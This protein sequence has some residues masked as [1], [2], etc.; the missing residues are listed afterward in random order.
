MRGPASAIKLLQRL[1]ILPIAFAAGAV[2]TG[3]PDAEP[4]FSSI[5]GDKTWDSL[6]QDERDQLACEDAP[7]YTESLVTEDEVQRAVC[8][9][10]GYGA[11][12]AAYLMGDG[13]EAAAVEACQAAYDT[14]LEGDEGGEEEGGTEC[15]AGY[16]ESCTFTVDQLQAC[17]D[18]TA[19]AFKEAAAQTCDGIDWAAEPET[20]DSPACDA[21]NES[22]EG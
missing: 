19:E 15:M 20:P 11:G 14:C 1:S 6:S 10:F 13:D 7:D 21:V 12:A 9:G 5:E 16:D 22:C 3:C 17:A 2:L 18:E 4:E 8:Y